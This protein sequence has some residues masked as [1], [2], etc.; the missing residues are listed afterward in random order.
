MHNSMHNISTKSI[1]VF[2]VYIYLFYTIIS[3][4]TAELKILFLY[5]KAFAFFSNIPNPFLTNTVPFLMGVRY[6][7]SIPGSLVGPT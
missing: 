2:I 3:L 7:R 6:Y 1:L 5:N 4:K